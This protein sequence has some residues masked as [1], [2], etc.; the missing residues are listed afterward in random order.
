VTRVTANKGTNAP[1]SIG[2]D[3]E[4]DQRTNGTITIGGTVYFDSY[5][6]AFQN[7]GETYLA[8]SPLVYEPK[9]QT[10]SNQQ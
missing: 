3:K 6:R 9:K 4:G 5:V 10:E 7:G 8:N 2:R 1:Y